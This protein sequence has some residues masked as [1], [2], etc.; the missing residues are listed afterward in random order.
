MIKLL[1]AVLVLFAC[2][3]LALQHTAK[4]RTALQG[5]RELK[6]LMIFLQQ[7]ISFHLEP[8]PDIVRRL[9]REQENGADSFLARLGEALEGQ[10]ELSFSRAWSRAV[11]RFAE[12]KG[13]AAR[14]RELVHALGQSLG[15]MD[16]ETEADRLL[17][18]A[19]ELETLLQEAEPALKQS[20]KTTRS[21]GFLS[22]VLLVILFI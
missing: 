20:E 8:L 7:R 19:R 12:E 3:V 15:T 21:L 10:E 2:T 1:G 16:S 18:C 9:C 17:N 5:V 14:A 4:K 11:S 22:G 6:E 13:I